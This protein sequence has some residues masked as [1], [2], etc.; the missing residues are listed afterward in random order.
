[1]GLTSKERKKS[2]S[3]SGGVTI[4]VLSPRGEIASE[5]KEAVAGLSPRIAGLA[6]KKVGLVDNLKAGTELLL[7]KVEEELRGKDSGRQG[8]PV[9]EAPGNGHHQNA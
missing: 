7:N 9:H 4:E 2:S 3:G 8:P 6:G 5:P 1:M